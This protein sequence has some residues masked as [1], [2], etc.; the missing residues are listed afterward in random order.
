MIEIRDVR[1]PAARRAFVTFPERLYARHPCYVPKFVRDELKTLDPARNPAFEYCEARLWMAYR[2]GTPVGRVAG[3][4]SRR[5]NDTWG[6][7][8]AR[9]GW[10]DFVDDP[11]V[12]A[13]LLHTVEAWA[14]SL[15]LDAVHGP[16]G[17]CDLDR[18]GMLV[19]G[20]DELDM[21]ITNYNFPYYPAHLD[22]LGYV[23]DADWVEY[24]VK[25][26]A[27][28]PE[29]VERI[30]R[31]VLDRARL[32]LVPTRSR[33]DLL[34]FVRGVFGVIN[35]TY[36]NL[37]AVV[38]VSERQ[39]DY[40]TRTFFGFLDHEL[41]TIV[42]DRDDRVAAFGIAMPSLSRALQRC[43]AR[44]LPF[45][46]LHVLG[47]LRWNDRLDLLLTAV[48]PDVQNKGVN[49]VLI[50]ETWKVAVRRRMRFAET[51]PELETNEKI[52]SQWKHFDARQH[53]RRRCYVKALRGGVEAPSGVVRQ[54]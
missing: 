4:V 5:S 17:F 45:G 11:A 41:V 49:A 54:A 43:R 18:E 12:S 44:L 35:E 2:D 51:G 13:A 10:L 32:R 47:A 16:L 26:P 15:G 1:S 29:N 20:F 42:V 7:K 50:N 40:Y 21:L 33:R 22:R 27:T 3:I 34:P 24:L 28:M 8:R 19:E 39:I 6:Q 53:R 31:V 25:V 52:Q 23:R 30:S 38:P 37:Y 46:F 9:F 48:R 36:K 14:A